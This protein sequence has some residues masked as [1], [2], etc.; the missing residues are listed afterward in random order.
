MI[1]IDARMIVSG[2][3]SGDDDSDDD[4]ND[5]VDY[6][7]EWNKTIFEYRLIWKRQRLIDGYPCIKRETGKRGGGGGG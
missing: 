2:C 7:L 4:A 3:G 5:D 6:A 1:G